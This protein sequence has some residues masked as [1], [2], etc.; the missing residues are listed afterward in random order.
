MEDACFELAELWN[1]DGL[2]NDRLLLADRAW[3][4]E[5]DPER[6]LAWHHLVMALGSFKRQTG[7]RIYLANLSDLG[8]RQTTSGQPRGEFLVP[9]S[10]RLAVVGRSDTW[11]LGFFIMVLLLSLVRFVGILSTTRRWNAHRHCI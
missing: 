7:R 3:T 6:T 10:S 2:W 1:D 5:S 11:N 8:L 9:K 4:A